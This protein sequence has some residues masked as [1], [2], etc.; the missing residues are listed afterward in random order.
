MYLSHLVYG[1]QD[2]L[3]ILS[4]SDDPSVY[5]VIGILLTGVAGTLEDTLNWLPGNC[6]ATRIDEQPVA[7]RIAPRAHL[8]L[9]PINP[10]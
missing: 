9:P 1:G 7:R 10:K 8:E 5:F 2:T 4:G 6:G 3:D